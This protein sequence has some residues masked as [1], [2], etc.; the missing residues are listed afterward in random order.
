MQNDRQEPAG[1]N[2]DWTFISPHDHLAL[3][4]KLCAM[5]IFEKRPASVRRAIMRFTYRGEDAVQTKERI[6]A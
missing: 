1:V 5:A 6:V 4:N 3:G 2:D